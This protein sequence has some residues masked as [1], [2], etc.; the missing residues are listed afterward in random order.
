MRPKNLDGTQ[1]QGRQKEENDNTHATVVNMVL[2]HC[3]LTRFSIENYESIAL[4]RQSTHPL[5]NFLVTEEWTLM[6]LIYVKK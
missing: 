4:D 1:T 3:A 6:T 5:E 2:E